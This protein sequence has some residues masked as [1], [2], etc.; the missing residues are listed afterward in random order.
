[1][2]N[3]KSLVFT[4]L[5]KCILYTGTCE[6]SDKQLNSTVYEKKYPALSTEFTYGTT[7]FKKFEGYN[8]V[9]DTSLDT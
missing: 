8:T 5:N 6:P 1:M 2:D 9:S 4:S 3:C 7:K